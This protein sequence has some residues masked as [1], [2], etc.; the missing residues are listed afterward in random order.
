MP[1]PVVLAAVAEIG[2]AAAL[3]T[4]A[5]RIAPAVMARVGPMLEQAVANGTAA[6][7]AR[8]WAAGELAN[9]GADLLGGVMDTVKAGAA[10]YAMYQ[11]V[12]ELESNG[13]FEGLMRAFEQGEGPFAQLLELVAQDASVGPSEFARILGEGMKDSEIARLLSAL[14]G[15]GVDLQS[16]L[17][18]MAAQAGVQGEITPDMVRSTLQAALEGQ[19]VAL[20][21]GQR[22]ALVPAEAVR[23]ALAQREQVAAGEAET[24][25]DMAL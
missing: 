5:M 20:S 23:E 9:H 7:A 15:E 25:A 12:S 24:E 4:A 17:Q 10:A 3:R 19:D 18:G 13:G 14:G 11:V 8:W 21:D 2:G 16:A 6:T 22:E 1:I